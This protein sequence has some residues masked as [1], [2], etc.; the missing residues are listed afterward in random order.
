MMMATA[1]SLAGLRVGNP[2][3][4]SLDETNPLLAHKMED[5]W[6]KMQSQEVPLARP[7]N[8]SAA[9]GVTGLA[10]Q[11]SKLDGTPNLSANFSAAASRD[12][13][14]AASARR[15]IGPEQEAHHLPA[16]VR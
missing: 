13:S 10:P 5:E 16:P 14:P 7:S 3:D 6:R 11:D 8:S 15:V 12:P 2:P 9:A 4:K 1:A